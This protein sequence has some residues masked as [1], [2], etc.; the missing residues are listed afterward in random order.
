MK[1]SQLYSN[2]ANIFTDIQFNDGLNVIVGNILDPNNLK[3]DSHNLGKSTFGHI[4]NFTLLC[5][6]SAVPFLFKDEKFCEFEFF[7]EVELNEQFMTVH[8]TVSENT[9][10]S[11]AFHNEKN[12]DFRQQNKDVWAHYKIPFDRAKSIVDAALQF[13]AIKPWDYRFATSY[14]IRNQSD[15]S[16]VFQLNKFRGSHKDWKP[17]ISHL[18]NFDFE[19]IKKN[20][21]LAILI[22]ELNKELRKLEPEVTGYLDSYDRIEGLILLKEKSCTEISEQLDNFDFTNVD[23]QNTEEIVQ[24]LEKK[25]QGYN[26]D[27]YYLKKEIVKI[28]ESLEQDIIR[29]KARNLEKLFGE[30]G[31]NFPDQITK[32]FD[33][34]IKFNKAISKERSEIL[35]NELKRFKKEYAELDIKITSVNQSLSQQLSFL[36]EKDSIKKFK[37]AQKQL[38]DLKAELVILT[39]KALKLKEYNSKQRTLAN[40]KSKKEALV[41]SIKDNISRK[42]EDQRS[43][44]SKVRL[45]FAKIIKGILN[46]D[47]LIE[48]RQ[49][50][51]GNLEFSTDF[52][53]ATGEITSESDGYTYKKLLCMAFDI[54]INMVYR[55]KQFPHF[56]FHDGV[57]DNLDVRKKINFIELCRKV[58][59]DGLQYIITFIDSDLPEDAL[60]S[61]PN[62]DYI[63]KLH[64]QGVDGR[65]FKMPLW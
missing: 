50:N 55:D 46:K 37:Q 36:K 6:S 57:F 27:R 61:F 24:V 59:G 38:V 54:A 31:I 13:D 60:N 56:I 45:E 4:L 47:A 49:N 30:A 1:L 9:K 48:S 44:Y 25:L 65:L 35:R 5:K 52:I 22:K 43:I 34:L 10:I 21:E 23:R 32:R 7:L 40:V 3:K 14:S 11:I 63:L 12:L 15:Y 39:E 42:A 33:D 51:E 8:R 18:F 19:A 29:I 2:K 17:Y 62:E 53:S 58:T 28:E 20:Y 41:E 64:D 16:N 26:S